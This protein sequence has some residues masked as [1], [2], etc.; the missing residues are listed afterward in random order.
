MDV[1][2][3]GAQR[4]VRADEDVLEHVLGV[5]ARTRAQHLAHVG[6]QPLAVAVVDDAERLVAPGAE[7]REQLLVRAQAEQRHA[8]RQPAQAHRCMQC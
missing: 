6:E 3:V 5:L 4:S 7:Q 8:E 1:A 2:L